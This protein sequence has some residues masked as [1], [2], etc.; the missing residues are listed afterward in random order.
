MKPIEGEI[1]TI[2]PNES[3]IWRDRKNHQTISEISLCRQQENICWR[4]RWPEYLAWQS[5]RLESFY[6][7]FD[8]RVRKFKAIVPSS[9]PRGKPLDS[10]ADLVKTFWGGFQSRLD[11]EPEGVR[12]NIPYIPQGGGGK[13]SRS[14]SLGRGFNLSAQLNASKNYVDVNLTVG[15]K[16]Y[17]LFMELHSQREAVT[18]EIGSEAEWKLNAS[19][20]SWVI[21]RRYVELADVGAREATYDWLLEKL[22]R[23]HEAFL[24]RISMLTGSAKV[25]SQRDIDC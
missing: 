25:M 17:D 1:D 6:K 16:Q 15:S 14:K 8:P 24:L 13:S 18:H 23:F 11:R 21:V 20:E 5:E 3:F 22:M 2:L 7:A 12:L 4:G 9:T 19:G 10:K